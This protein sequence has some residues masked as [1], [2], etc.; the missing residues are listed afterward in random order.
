[1]K[2]ID[3]KHFRILAIS[4]FYIFFCG[5]FVTAQYSCE[6]PLVIPDGSIKTNVI[7]D[8]SYPVVVSSDL[9]KGVDN[10]NLLPCPTAGP[11][12][13]WI[14]FAIDPAAVWIQTKVYTIGNWT[15]VWSIHADVEC[16]NPDWLE[17]APDGIRPCSNSD[18]NKFI[19][20]V[21]RVP[22]VSTYYMAIGADK[23]ADIPDFN[24]EIWT[25]ADCFSC[26]G[27]AGCEPAAEWSVV[28][29]S[30]GKELD[31]PEFCQGE[32][33]R[34]CFSFLYDA[35][36][37]GVDWFHALFPSFGSGWDMNYFNPASVQ[38]FPAGAEWI[39]QNDIN[40]RAKSNEILPFLCTYTDPLTGL[41]KLCNTQCEP[42]PCNGPLPAD[43]FLP[44]GWFWN[45]NGGAGCENTCAPHTRYGIGSVVT[46]INICMDLKVRTFENAQQASEGR[47][48][49][50]NFH[51]TSDGVTG[52]WNDP[53]AEC[54]RDYAQ[55]G[56]DW[57]VSCD[58]FEP[59]PI[60]RFFVY[61]DENQNGKYDGGPESGLVNCAITIDELNT[62]YYT[63]QS[64]NAKVF[65]DT[66]TY[67]VTY[68]M[69][70]GSWAE[71]TITKT[72]SHLDLVTADSVGFLPFK[73]PPTGTAHI[74]S[75]F[76]RCEREIDLI[77]Y[78]LNTSSERINGQIS[79]SYDT[80]VGLLNFIPPPDQRINNKAWWNFTNL[81]SGETFYINSKVRIPI[82]NQN[83]DSLRFRIYMVTDAG[84]TLSQNK[85]ADIIRCS[86]DPNDKL[87]FPD[88]YGDENFTL[89]DESLIYTIRFQNTGNDTAYH[90]TIRD[91]LDPQIDKSSLLLLASSHDTELRMTGDTLWAVFNN[92]YLPDST[93]NETESQGFITFRIDFFKDIPNESRIF[94]FADIYF[95]GNEPI[96]TNQ[97]INTVVD[98]L[99]CSDV[100]YSVTQNFIMTPNLANWY[101]WY[102]CNSNEILTEG[103]SNIFIPVKSG[104]YFVEFNDQFCTVRSECIEFI[105]SGTN[106][107]NAQTIRIFPNPSVHGFQISGY[108]KGDQLSLWN[109]M[110]Q[111][112]FSAALPDQLYYDFDP[113]LYL[114]SGV[115]NILLQSSDSN[116]IFK[117]VK[118]K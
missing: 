31:D 28:S 70:Y 73:V 17:T 3:S 2:K 27:N 101:K 118:T 20:T 41:L 1:M 91:I 85:Y 108:K 89:R 16:E 66:G 67:T 7:C 106:E 75:N 53:A 51:T 26:I 55:I 116:Y 49:R 36:E 23:I 63:F 97:T 15:P 35:S 83:T 56:P 30:S 8:L 60:V 29:R 45:T 65:I 37:T 111:K 43:S 81:Q 10:L 87:T 100:E 14:K 92:I 64:G 78:A 44:S 79:M 54:K 13:V 6:S 84:D 24:V 99:P 32:E 61:S 82:G 96:R 11:K 68:R 9:T 76:L 42:C 93:T 103:L 107:Q 72:I 25:T 114:N 50:I 62:T 4:L 98:L 21:K 69:N 38:A 90:V 5:N 102:D 52:C 47:N 34:F 19:H 105:L 22:G 94:N 57:K 110:G 39:D 115:Y 71:N 33:V 59:A 86:Y 40:C 113:K 46:N 18:K 48:L 88:R 77:S 80:R 12:V 117:W 109:A 74:I 58:T 104:Y 95:D 112:I